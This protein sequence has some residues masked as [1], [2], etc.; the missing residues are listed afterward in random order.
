MPIIKY[1]PTTPGRRQMS[2]PTFE[3]ITRSKPEK[4]LTLILKRNSGRNHSGTI[5][6][7]HRGGG[8]KRRYR[9]IDF[10]H[11]KKNLEA[12][13]TSIEYDPNRSAYIMLVIYTDGEKKYH[14]A[15]H[16]MKV[17]DK[18]VTKERTKVKTGNRMML[19]NIPIGYDIHNVE[20]Y[21]SRGGQLARSAG[22]SLKLVSLEGP[23]AQIQMRSGEVR[24]VSKNCYASIGIV[25]NI[26]HNN[27][28]IGKAGRKRH[29]GWRP[30]V[31]GSAMN[32]VDHPH[33]GGEGRTPIGLKY[34][35][36][37]WGMPTLGFKT[38]KRKYTNK[39]IIKDRRIK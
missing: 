21:E 26:D 32:P 31:R 5:T 23:H 10:M 20:L 18:I 27:V 35:K 11:T 17:G 6:V 1:K 29:M 14:L 38:R 34:P 12:R 25:S 28:S 22:S 3:E 13:V 9:L 16:G 2:M 8:S 15:P 39:M 30:T 19:K 33:G 7:R 36:T 4:S 37:P 24:I